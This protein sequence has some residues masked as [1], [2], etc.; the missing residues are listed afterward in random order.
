MELNF[1]KNNNNED[2]LNILKFYF[3]EIKKNKKI[4]N[5][6]ELRE[7][8]YYPFP[9]DDNYDILS[10]IRNKFEGKFKI[11]NFYYGF[12]HENNEE[13]YEIFSKE[14]FGKINDILNENVKYVGINLREVMECYCEY[15][16]IFAY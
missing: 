3:E 1:I 11:K 12:I 2:E 9:E 13:N 7:E 8:L 5:E 14:M 16:L 6:I 4:L 10:Q 15:L